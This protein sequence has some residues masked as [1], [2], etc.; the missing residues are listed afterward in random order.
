MN[1]APPHK[2]LVIDDERPIL[3]TLE[4]LLK[5]H[6]YAPLLANTAGGG[7]SVVRKEKPDLVLLD[8]GVPDADGMDVLREMKAEF[9]DLQVIILTA[10]D[11]LSNAIDSIKL[12]AF[13]FTRSCAAGTAR[14]ITARTAS[15]SGRCA[16]GNFARSRSTSP[17]PVISL[18]AFGARAAFRAA[19]TSLRVPRDVHPH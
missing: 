16:A 2:V 5:R 15:T 18:G 19:T 9:R 11:S 8:L 7:T 3:M 13:H 1:L 17:D 4:A 6:G 10:H 14:A 12:G